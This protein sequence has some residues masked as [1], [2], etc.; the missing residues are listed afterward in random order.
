MIART[1]W[2]IVSFLFLSACAEAIPPMQEELSSKT[3]P[4]YEGR[5]SSLQTPVPLVY[6]P[7]R[8]RL[9]GT[10]GIYKNVR[11]RDELFTGE[12]SGRLKVSPASDSLLWE[13][14]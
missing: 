11:D 10:F 6:R 12:L 5:F 14:S 2:I 9:A 13:F 1:Y 4:M 7:V 8:M 3:L